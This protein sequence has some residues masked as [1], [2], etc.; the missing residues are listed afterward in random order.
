MLE[1]LRIRWYREGCFKWL[2]LIFFRCLSCDFYPDFL[3]GQAHQSA[4]KTRPYSCSTRRDGDWVSVSGGKRNHWNVADFSVIEQILTVP[5]DVA[6]GNALSPGLK[7]IGM[8]EILS[9]VLRVKFA[10]FAALIWK[11][12]IEPATVSKPPGYVPMQM[13]ADCWVDGEP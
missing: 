5:L 13:T 4:T 1:S 6:P 3:M 8:G 2:K 11:V 12:K 7:T 9:V 10:W